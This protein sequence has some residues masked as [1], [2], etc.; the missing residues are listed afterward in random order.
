MKYHRRRQKLSVQVEVDTWLTI[1]VQFSEV[2]ENYHAIAMPRTYIASYA[3][4]QISGI[5]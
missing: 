5:C 4:M 1:L 3:R 2:L